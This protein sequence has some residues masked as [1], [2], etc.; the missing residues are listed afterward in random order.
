MYLSTLLLFP[1]SDWNNQPSKPAAPENTKKKKRRVISIKRFIM[2][3][4]PQN[5]LFHFCNR[6]IGP[7]DRIEVIESYNLTFK[8]L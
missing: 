7:I 2:N 6:I 4:S 1:N 3:K 5:N 8:V